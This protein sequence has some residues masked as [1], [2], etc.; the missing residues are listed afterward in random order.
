M[1]KVSFIMITARTDFP[2][3]NRPDLHLFEPTIESLKTQ[4]M[5][6]WG[7]L[8]VVDVLYDKRKDYFKDKE[9]PFPVK[10]IPARPNFWLDRGLPG[11]CEQYNKGIV[12]A[13]GDLLFFTGDSYMFRP[14]F[15]SRMWTAYLQGGF[16]LV[17]YLFDFGK[18]PKPEKTPVPY[19]IQGFTGENVHVEHRFH[20]SF[21]DG[22]ESREAPWSWWYGCSTASLDAMLEINGF[23]LLCEPDQYLLDCDVGSRLN[24]AGYKFTLH[25]E[26]FYVRIPTVVKTWSSAVRKAAVSIKCNLPLIWVSR[27]KNRFKANVEKLTVEDVDWIKWVWCGKWC[28][29]R[30]LCKRE[31]PWQYPFQHK[32][33]GESDPLSKHSARTAESSQEWYDLWFNS[34]RLVDLKWEREL[35]VDGDPKYSEGTFID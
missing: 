7:E 6:E 29:I 8:V 5:K 13:D 18:E 12:Y 22:G 1:V 32:P 9:L 14:D 4:N 30:E 3:K 16:P 24:L 27:S 11:F 25:R 10:H 28:Q 15:L 19:D 21:K 35:R 23:N 17:W 34:Q 20:D 2:Y 26:L 33:R 31:H